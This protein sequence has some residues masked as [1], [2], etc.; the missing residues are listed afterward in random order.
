MVTLFKVCLGVMAICKQKE[1]RYQLVTLPPPDDVVC[2]ICLDIVVEPHQLTCCGQHLCKGCGQDLIDSPCPLCRDT[3]HQI[4][5][6]KYFERNTLN[7]LRV[8]CEKCEEGCEWEDELRAR[9]KHMV[10]CPCVE[11]DCPYQCD[12]KCMRKLLNIHKMVCPRSPHQC[13]YCGYES[14]YT[15]VT[16]VH[17]PLCDKA[18]VLCPNECAG[19]T[20]I[21]REALPNHIEKE[22]PL[23]MV[24]CEFS[25]VCH[26]TMPR[27][28][29]PQH[30]T[31]YAQHHTALM[32]KEV[33]DKLM[34]MLQDK[35]RQLKEKDQQLI[36]KDQQLHA[37][38]RKMEEKDEQL[39]EKDQQLSAKDRR[40]EEKDKQLQEKD[41]EM[42]E[43]LK[44]KDQQL[45]MLQD[46]GQL[47]EKNQRLYA[48]I[49][50]RNQ[51]LKEK[52]HQMKEK[53]Q[54][55][56]DKDQQLNAKDRKIEERDQQL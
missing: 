55:L 17:M 4:T 54:R 45:M 1:Y 24:P 37:K 28:D 18:P 36:Y 13:E 6:D 29:L 31:E 3:S 5:P 44:N 8:R 15:D 41:S 2:P 48:I 32:T 19:E 52:D 22:C 12:T 23:Q 43:R 14:T 16:Y 27:K 49:E 30:L 9:A 10:T 7:C 20:T 21:T 40:I 39:K 47:E 51:Q 38:D 33:K 56:K 25:N 11:E 26:V 50:E 46:K 34:E 42:R 35:D 53:D